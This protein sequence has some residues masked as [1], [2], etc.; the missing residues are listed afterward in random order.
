MANSS[1]PYQQLEK[2]LRIT[3]D[4]LK[5]LANIPVKIL[6]I[7]KS[8]LIIRDIDIIRNLLGAVVCFSFTTLDKKLAKKLEPGAPEPECRL[9]ALSVLSR[10]V[11]TAARL[12][13]LVWP[14]TTSDIA[15]TIK[16][17]KAAGAKQIITSTYKARP[18]N[19]KKM[20]QVFPEYS[21]I[22]KKA[23]AEEGKSIEGSCYLPENKRKRLIQKVRD[24]SLSEGILFSSCRE[25]M[26]SLNTALCDGQQLFG[27]L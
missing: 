12:D 1:D 11:P 3:R 16:I 6:F 17:L 27:R 13:P 20:F 21:K 19:F 18:L 7:T 4:G 22:W 5:I 24:A 14:L 10:Y 15:G 25:G 2:K 23:Y 9:K 26:V 8:C